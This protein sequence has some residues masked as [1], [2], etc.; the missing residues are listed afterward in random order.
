MRSRSQD[1]DS[2][3]S[4]L[5]H[6]KPAHPTTAT[7][8]PCLARSD[9]SCTAQC[10]QTTIRADLVLYSQETVPL[11]AAEH[12]RRIA[13][14]DGGASHPDSRAKTEPLKRPGIDLAGC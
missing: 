4:K 3:R 9:M 2:Q 13:C 14:S 1:P 11:V 5:R 6:Q 12:P 8:L 7:E 10:P